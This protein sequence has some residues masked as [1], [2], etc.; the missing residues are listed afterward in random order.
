MPGRIEIEDRQLVLER[1]F[2]EQ[3]FGRFRVVE[4][5]P[6]LRMVD[7]LATGSSLWSFISSSPAYLSVCRQQRPFHRTRLSGR[8]ELEFRNLIEVDLPFGDPRITRILHRQP[9]FRRPSDHF[10]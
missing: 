3:A 9:A 10:G 2:A 5:I 6:L 8:C 7:V 1:G 4:D